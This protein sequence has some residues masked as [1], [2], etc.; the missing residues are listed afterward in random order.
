MRIIFGTGVPP[1][2]SPG[3][4]VVVKLLKVVAQGVNDSYQ[5]DDGR[6]WCGR[7]SAELETDEERKDG[8]CYVCLGDIVK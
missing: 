8:R 4:R 5:T 3:E 2:T 1:S 6:W 7:C